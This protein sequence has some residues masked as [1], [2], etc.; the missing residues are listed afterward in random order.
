V[1]LTRQIDYVRGSVSP[2][3]KHTPVEYAQMGRVFCS[4]DFS[5]GPALTKAAIDVLG[6]Q[7]FMFAS[8]Y[9][10]PET[11][12]PDHADTVIAWRTV[13]G[14]ETMQKLMWENASR[15]LRLTSTPWSSAK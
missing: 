2:T 10:H 9:P 5:E 3:L 11:I 14:E 8:D 15:F 1:R 4:I 12:F 6:D 7:A 13:L